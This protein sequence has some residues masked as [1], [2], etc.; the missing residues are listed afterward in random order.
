MLPSREI[1]RTTL[2]P[3]VQIATIIQRDATLRFSPKIKA[4]KNPMSQRKTPMNFCLVL[5]LSS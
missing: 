4:R 3:T 2:S 5:S 1:F